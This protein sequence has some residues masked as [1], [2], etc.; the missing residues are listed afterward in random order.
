[1]VYLEI[2]DNLNVKSFGSWE[3]EP[4]QC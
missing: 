3:P 1:M 4:M 2:P